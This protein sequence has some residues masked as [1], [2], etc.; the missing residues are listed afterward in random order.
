MPSARDQV[1]AIGIDFGTTN[2][3]VARSSGK[4]QV[5]LVAFPTLTG[6]TFSFRSVLYLQQI[7]QAARTKTQTW[8]GPAAIE[9]YLAAE[10]KGRLIQSLKSYLSDRSLTGTAVFGRHCT[11]EDLISRILADLRRHA[12]RQFHIEIGYAMVGRPVRFV[13]A[14]TAEDE[15]FALGRLREAFAAAG[16]EHI[17][18]E[19]EPVAAAYAYEA[20]LDH[21]ELILI[22]DF[23]GGTSD[24]SLLHVGPGVRK[25]GRTPQDLLGNSGVGLAGDAFDARIVR[26]LVS[27]ALG[28]DSLARSLNKL[29]PAVPA[30][31]YANLERWHYLSFLRTSNVVEILK[32]ARLRALE[33]EKIE[34]LIT[35]I[36]EDLGYHLHQAVQQLKFELSRSESA[37]FHFRDGSMDLNIAVTRESFESWIADDLRTIEQCVD[38]LLETSG[39]GRSQVDRVFLTGGTSLVPAVR[40]IFEHRFGEQR[41]RTGNEFI[42]VARGLALRAEEVLAQ[43][44]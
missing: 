40:R 36:D 24:F 39:V 35:L 4:S 32:S 42:S 21:D 27:P 28:S 17:D 26:K 30:W 25:R 1:S 10:N 34:A 37:E 20:T 33:P 2:S 3:T 9:H 16:F 43:L 14:E 23:G 5:E 6:E 29:L 44:R 22:G 13:G 38:S 7:K 41:I 19:M 11:L 18:F 12:E 8:T 31:I 15:T